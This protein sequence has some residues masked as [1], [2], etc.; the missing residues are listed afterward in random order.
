MT[1]DEVIASF[2]RE[3]ADRPSTQRRGRGFWVVTGTLILAT[4]VVVVEIFANRPMADTIGHA[5]SSLRDAQAAAERVRREEG[6]YAGAD[7]RGLNGVEQDL[8]FLEPDEPSAGL[9]DVSVIA[10]AGGWA[11]A[12]QA[13]PGACFYLR[14]DADGTEH[15]GVG[16][17]CTAR[18]ALQANESQW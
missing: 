16:T 8:R 3:F 10:S 2:E 4:V 18:D 7:A 6:T 15:F 12:V 9:D 14:L 1:D 13:R 5:E 17:G 11:A